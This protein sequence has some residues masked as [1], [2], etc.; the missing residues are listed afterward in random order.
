MHGMEYPEESG[1]DKLTRLRLSRS[2]GA[3]GKHSSLAKHVSYTCR[4]LSCVD[5]S[6]CTSLGLSCSP[7]SLSA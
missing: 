3:T 6:T 7:L 2:D 4:F 1:S 5:F